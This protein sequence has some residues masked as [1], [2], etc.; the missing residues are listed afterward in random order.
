MKKTDLAYYAGIF[1]GEGTV[2]IIERKPSKKGN[3]P[4][5]YLAVTICST[6]EWLV[7]QL[8]FAFGGSVYK[9]KS[10]QPQNH[11]VWGWTIACKKAI[12]FLEVIL[13]YLHLKRAQVE[14]GLRMQRTV[15]N[16]GGEKLQRRLTDGEVAWR[17]AQKILISNLNHKRSN[18]D[19]KD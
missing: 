7:R 8:Q 12:A 18:L 16:K 6:D 11:P 3:N 13:P 5:F 17:Q 10:S 9:G 15:R 19:G 1:D 2:G 4:N 14:I